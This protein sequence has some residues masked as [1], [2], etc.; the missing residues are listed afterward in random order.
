MIEQFIN[1]KKNRRHNSIVRCSM[2]YEFNFI[3][4]ETIKEWILYPENPF[5]LIGIA[6]KYKNFPFSKEYVDALTI[7]DFTNKSEE[8]FGKPINTMFSERLGI[9]AYDNL[10]GVGFTIDFNASKVDFVPYYSRF[11]GFISAFL[12]EQNYVYLQSE[13]VPGHYKY[14]GGLKIIKNQYGEK[15]VDLSD[16]PGRQALHPKFIYCGASQMWFGEA[17]YKIIPKEKIL[18]F[19][20]ALAINQLENNVTHV[21]LYETIFD[22]DRPDNQEVQR[23]FREHLG[24]DGI[25]AL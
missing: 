9:G 13:K 17:F 22:G 12:F 19:D 25:T 18:S 4:I 11:K 8:F 3:K 20:K 16:R 5:P 1:W 2:Y 23:A 14:K 15:E 21:H 7:A 6:G 24:I 10:L